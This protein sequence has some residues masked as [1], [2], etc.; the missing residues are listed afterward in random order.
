MRDDDTKT[1][2]AIAV[3]H[4]HIPDMVEM[5]SSLNSK[6]IMV[7]MATATPVW[8]SMGVGTFRIGAVLPIW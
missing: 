4:V 7:V 1:A 5:V 8:M 3:P 6:A 2:T